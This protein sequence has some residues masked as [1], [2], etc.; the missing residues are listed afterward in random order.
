MRRLICLMLLFGGSLPL[1]QSPSPGTFGDLVHE[2]HHQ[3]PANFASQRDAMNASYDDG[4]T[5]GYCLGSLGT[6]IS[7]LQDSGEIQVPGDPLTQTTRA[8]EIITEYLNKNPGES[9]S[10]V[11]ITL[12]KAL[13]AQ[14]GVH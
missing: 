2:C 10:P 11:A 12:K 5:S 4:Y 7:L 14:W 8:K 9:N 1:A 3:S 13:K 6:A